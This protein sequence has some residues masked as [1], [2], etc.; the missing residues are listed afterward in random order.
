MKRVFACCLAILIMIATAGCSSLNHD[1]ENTV[2]FYY[3]R[4]EYDYQAEMPVI[5]PEYREVTGHRNDLDYLVSLY[6]MGPLNNELV[7][8]FPA[9]TRLVKTAQENASLTVELTD[10]GRA[11]SDIRFSLAC[12][13]LSKTCMELTEVQSVTVVSGSR[14]LTTTEESLLLIDN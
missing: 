14:R 5:A 13:C 12:A 9:G 2:S 1:F 6:L 4:V 11:L 8:P 10:T 3:P 7:V